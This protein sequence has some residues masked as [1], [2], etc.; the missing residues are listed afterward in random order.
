MR[1]RCRIESDWAKPTMLIT[2]TVSRPTL[3]A[4]RGDYN[5]LYGQL[6][7][8]QSLGKTPLFGV[9][10]RLFSWPWLAAFLGDPAALFRACCPPPKKKA[11]NKAR[12]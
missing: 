3:P 5:M 4:G 1:R 12:H 2:G 8:S 7:S 10:P 11:Q 6:A 9:P